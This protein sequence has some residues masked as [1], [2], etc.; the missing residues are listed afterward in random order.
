VRHRASSIGRC[1][2]NAEPQS[3][4]QSDRASHMAC[5]AM[6]G[7]NAVPQTRRGQLGSILEQARKSSDARHGV[8]ARKLGQI[9]GETRRNDWLRCSCQRELAPFPLRLHSSPVRRLEADRGRG[10]QS[11][12]L[13]CMASPSTKSAPSCVMQPGR[14]ESEKLHVRRGRGYGLDENHDAR[15][16]THRIRSGGI[17]QSAMKRVRRAC[18]T[19]GCASTRL[20]ETRVVR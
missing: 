16:G 15:R 18:R 9:C 19:D 17:E 3:A 2:H 12:S 7:P 14:P 20:C 1:L 10:S 13:S 11:A 5:H 4:L 8:A 6:I